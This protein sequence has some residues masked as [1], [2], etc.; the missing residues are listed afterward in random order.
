MFVRNK[1]YDWY[2]ALVTS[3]RTNEAI[4]FETERHHIIPT[5]LGGVDIVEN[6]VHL[7]YREHFLAHW[8]LTKFTAGEDKRKML[9]ALVNFTRPKH[10]GKIVSGW[11]FAKMRK[12]YSEC[13]RGHVKS[14]QHREKLARCNIGKR[15]IRS[16]EDPSVRKSLTPIKAEFLV[17][18]GF[19][20]Y[21][22]V[23]RPDLATR[24]RISP[25]ESTRA[26]M[27]NSAQSRRPISES[28][29]KKLSENN[30]K[31]KAR[32]EREVAL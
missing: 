22:S 25:S 11:Q 10:A 15:V 13:N 23:A 26:K 28:T 31:R 27:S 4:R 32:L 14:D 9:F 6:T 5:A 1:Y 21:G 3:R 30:Y 17:A 19:W 24:N 16:I 7:T 18:S 2:M 12:A 8:L 29:R 20:E